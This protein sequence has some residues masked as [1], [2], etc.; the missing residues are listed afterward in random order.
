MIFALTISSAVVLGGGGIDLLRVTNDRKYLQERVDATALFV[1]GPA[2][3]A[4]LDATVEALVV[5]DDGSWV[6]TPGL[7][8]VAA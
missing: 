5:C 8:G 2:G 6:A 4:D 1:A 3:T 7:A